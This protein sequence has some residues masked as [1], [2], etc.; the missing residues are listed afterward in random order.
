MSMT[1]ARISHWTSGTVALTVLATASAGLALVLCAVAASAIA[2]ALPTGAAL[3]V[4]ER[5]ISVD[6]LDQRGRVLR[7][8]YGVTPPSD[9][10]ELDTYRRGMAK[11]MAIATVT[12]Q[13]A[14]RRGL[15]SGLPHSR[16]LLER[17]VAA[18]FSGN[19]DAFAAELSTSGASE[20]QLLEE[21]ALQAT[22]ARLFDAVTQNVP[23]PTEGELRAAY[24]GARNELVVP[25]QRELRIIVES[26]RDQAQQALAQINSGTDFADV[27]R[28][29]S[30]DAV[31]RAAGGDL[32]VVPSAALEKPFADAAFAAGV[33][34]LFGPV[35]TR[36]GWYVGQ[37]TRDV[38]ARPLRFDEVS[39]ELRE[40]LDA[41]RMFVTWH[42]FIDRELRT[43]GVEYAPDYQPTE[44]VATFGLDPNL[45]PS[46]V[47][48][49]GVSPGR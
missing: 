21:I 9:G 38:P 45:D 22:S 8:L 6:E 20:P 7:A 11:S 37:V 46:A 25:E 16:E 18:N 23:P 14:V 34:Q 29:R 41:Q 44:P 3:R 13:A 28:R 1:W 24:Q 4:G 12:R 40:Q 26:D 33:G 2:N 47:R 10:P 32:G 42:T 49:P 30:L 27:A 35:Q 5:V 31:T 39:G 19:R 17:Y 15:L 36:D 43:S 48:A